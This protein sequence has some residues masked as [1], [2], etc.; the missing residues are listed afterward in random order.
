M[1]LNDVPQGAMNPAEAARRTLK[2]LAERRLTATPESFAQ[3]YQEVTGRRSGVA[4]LVVKD[5]LR[6]F[7]RSGRVSTQEAAQVL[8]QA[9]DNEWRAVHEAITLA[10][11][12]RVGA[13]GYHW[14]GTALA[15]LKQADGLHPNWTRARKLDAVTRVIDA[16]GDQPDIALERLNKLI[17]SWGPALA[18]A[19]PTEPVAEPTP[20]AAPPA[21]A[22]PATR[23][24][25]P[26]TDD[27]LKHA[28]AA[29][30][31]W[32]QVAQRAL[33]LLE[34]SCGNGAPAT[35]RLREYGKQHV[36]VAVEDIG[37]LV[38]RFTDVVAAVERRLDEQNKIKA[39]LA[40]MLALLCDNMR[41]LTPEETW[42]A[43]QLE[44]IRALLG[45]PLTAEDLSMAEHSL[46]MVIERQ[47]NARR[48]LQDAKLA[49]KEMLATLIQRIGTMGDSTGKFYQQV[50]DYQSRLEGANDFET[51]SAVIRGLLTDTQVMRADIQSS[52]TELL[53]ARRK[54]EAYETR[55]RELEREL[56]QVS[57]LVQRDPLTQAM[58]RRG[59]EEAFRAEA[60]RA[61]RYGSALSFLLIDVDDFKKVNDSLGHLGGD[62]ALV[63]LAQTLHA[64]LR[65]TDILVRLGGEEFGVMLPSTSIEDAGI[66]AD[67]LRRE[68]ARRPFVFEGR[69]CALTFSG[70]LAQWRGNESLEHWLERADAAMYRAKRAGKDRVEVAAESEIELRVIQPVHS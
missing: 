68:L 12:R 14:P 69:P 66:V 59:L 24:I 38:T 33:R 26:R 19:R 63:H 42:L 15:L 44:P 50:G 46:A 7:V 57:T 30:E 48:S 52:R 13:L 6:D 29:A 37:K 36:Q 34:Q 16:A 11:E 20:V 23:P 45:G 70:G 28:R 31:A 55:V 67:R 60:S 64:T 10:I 53:D 18:T 8:R 61:Q 2:L 1:K 43:G 62:R 65:P 27:A 25:E 22:R 49:L 39:G 47:V 35:A 32:Q 41:S 4:A 3:A 21:A 54:V 51:L 56:S 9:K 58:N 5:V 40:R 17:E